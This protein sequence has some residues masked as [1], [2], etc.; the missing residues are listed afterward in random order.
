MSKKDIKNN[1]LSQEVW[2]LAILIAGLLLLSLIPEITIGTFHFRKIDLLSDLHPTSLVANPVL[3]DSITATDSI[4]RP[5]HSYNPS[6]VRIEDYSGDGKI[7]GYFYDAMNKVHQRQVRIAFFGDSYIEGDII[8]AS[9]RDTLQHI[10]GGNG[11]GLVPM[12]SETSG[13]R[14]SV[15]HTFGGWNTHTLITA[16]NEDI[17]IG[18]S[19]Y[20]CVPERENFA[21]YQPGKIPPQK[22]FKKVNL[23][24]L[25]NG[26][27][28]VEYTIN[29]E[30]VIRE[31]LSSSNHIQELTFTHRGIE[32]IRFH[33]TPVENLYLFGVSFEDNYGVY[34]D[35]FSLRRNSGIALARLSPTLLKQ[36]NEFL[37]YKLIILQYGLNVASATDSTHYTWY[38]SKMVSIIKNLK[39]IFPHAS[40]LL[41]SVGDRGINKAGKVVTME[42]IPELRDIQR[43]IA[44]KSGIAFWDMFEAMGG[45]NSVANYTHAE[46]PLASKDYTHLTHLGGFKMGNI[47]G[48]VLIQ[49]INIHEE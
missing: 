25:N 42:A 4:S 46:P 8:S 38:S 47:L 26:S 41:L 16:T 17:P 3:S 13:F 49:E 33:I 5:K 1:V 18:I 31:K 44:K 21:T 36:F 10:F 39:E 9:F 6:L 29:D 45:K 35:N 34:V 15:K 43:S 22:N 2:V 30:P 11:V 14:K 40:F 28:S 19:G 7:L 23:F 20:T 32:T 24:Y 37:D 48:Q 27:A 12:A